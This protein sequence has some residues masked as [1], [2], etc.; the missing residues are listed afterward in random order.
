MKNLHLKNLTPFKKTYTFNVEKRVLHLLLIKELCSTMKLKYIYIQVY[1][2][3]LF[4]LGN[5]H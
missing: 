5:V 4:L 1:P 2:L 3:E